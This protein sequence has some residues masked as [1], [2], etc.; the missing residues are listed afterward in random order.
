MTLL[1]SDL[2]EIFQSCTQGCLDAVDIHW[3]SCFGVTIVLASGGY[4]L[5]TKL[6]TGKKISMDIHGENHPHVT[7][8]HAGTEK[9]ADG[10][11]NSGGRVLCVTSVSEQNFEAAIES[12]YKAVGSVQ[13][14]GMHYRKDIA[15]SA[16]VKNNEHSITYK[17]AGVDIKEADK[18]IDLIKPYCKVYHLLL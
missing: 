11:Y 14:E 15:Q 16:T 9:R 1:E 12:A 10:L 6:E 4:A 13:F 2:Y 7:V 3:K 5:E 18:F 8:F 17:E